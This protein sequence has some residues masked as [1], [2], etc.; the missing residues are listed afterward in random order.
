MVRMRR[1]G[2]LVSQSTASHVLEA[3]GAAGDGARA[4][5]RL[6]IG[7]FNTEAQIDRAA[8]CIARRVLALR[9]RR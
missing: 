1:V 5:L 3:I 4:A 7:R 8:Q 2:T 6:G 9:G